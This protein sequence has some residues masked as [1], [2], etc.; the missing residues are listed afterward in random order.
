MQHK[1]D[2]RARRRTAAPCR[3][4]LASATA[5]TPKIERRLGQPR[6]GRADRRD[7]TTLDQPRGQQHAANAAEQRIGDALGEQLPDDAQR[8]AAHRHAQRDLLLPRRRPRQQQVG[9]VRARD[10]QHTEAGGEQ[11]RRARDATAPTIR[12]CSG[13][14]TAG[15]R[16]ERRGI[17][18]CARVNRVRAPRAPARS[19]TPALSSPIAW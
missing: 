8:P 5:S 7:T 16:P 12:S 15:R 13:I 18:L 19:C 14:S 9:D 1:R 2:R 6:H 11:E 3:S 10:Q 4:R 17:L